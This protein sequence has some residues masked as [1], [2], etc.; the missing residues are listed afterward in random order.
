MERLN[1]VD[2]LNI[3]L[4]LLA[5]FI[6][7]KIIISYINTQ[8]SI[9]TAKK[10]LK[11][12]VFD[13]DETLGYFT[14]L[15][16]FW[17]ALEKFYGHRLFN[18]TFFDLMDTF[19]EFFRPNIFKIVDFIHSKKAC[20][21]II[22]YTNNQGP[23]SWV[24]MISEYF[25]HKLGYN[26]FDQIISAYKVNGRQIEP[27]R[28]THDKSIQDLFSIVEMPTNTEVC[29]IDDLYHPLM[30]KDNVFYINI[31]PYRC[32]LPFDEMASRYYEKVAY[33]NNKNIDETKFINFIIAFMEQYNYMV[34]NKTK[35]EEKTDIVVSK[36]LLSHL[37]DFLKRPKLSMTR[38]KRLRRTKSM[39]QQF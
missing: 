12:V 16:I 7:F 21:K 22:I 13:L 19:P 26:V 28:T 27:K 37:E 8:A 33:K 36:K 1:I 5:L 24:K 9:M 39:K 4:V 38:K 3:V 32:S 10:T 20:H 25:N 6:F 34:L 30:D 11:I 23:K 15:G 17:D 35:E 31:K 14:E 18:D 29:F 2:G